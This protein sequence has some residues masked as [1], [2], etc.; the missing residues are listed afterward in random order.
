MAVYRNLLKHYRGM[1]KIRAE[2][3]VR[4]EHVTIQTK[5]KNLDSM[6]WAYDLQMR[7]KIKSDRP[8]TRTAKQGSRCDLK[9]TREAA[10]KAI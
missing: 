4:F 1:F 10:H 2:N 7:T 3:M 8:E 9:T 5:K 6:A